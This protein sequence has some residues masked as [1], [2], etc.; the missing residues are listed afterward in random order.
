ME[1]KSFLYDL[2]KFIHFTGNPK[3]FFFFFFAAVI[4]K[5]ILGNIAIASLKQSLLLPL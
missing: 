2:S 1:K 3:Q 5:N 4:K